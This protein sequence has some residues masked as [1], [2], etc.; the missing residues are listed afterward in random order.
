M[1][2]CKEDVKGVQLPCLVLASS[3]ILSYRSTINILEANSCHA[4]TS[5]SLWTDILHFIKQQ[6]TLI[7]YSIQELRYEETSLL[8]KHTS[9][10]L[11]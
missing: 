11:A 4:V 7:K 8:M 6:I 1:E 2:R 10:A 9:F 5:C 3:C